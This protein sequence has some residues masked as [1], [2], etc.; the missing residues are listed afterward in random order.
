MRLRA[1]DFLCSLLSIACSFFSVPDSR[2]PVEPVV[3][4]EYQAKCNYG[5]NSCF[6]EANNLPWHGTQWNGNERD[7]MKGMSGVV[8]R[9][10]RGCAA[11]R[12]RCVIKTLIIQSIT[13]AIIGGRAVGGRGWGF[14]SYS[15]SIRD[16]SGLSGTSRYSLRV[17][18]CVKG[19]VEW[20]GAEEARERTVGTIV[21]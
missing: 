18:T 15:N 20:S 21:N 13:N 10:D 5:W 4:I 3:L 14:R 19:W 12:A 8:A 17:C 1:Y 2:S 9:G 11:G 7:R 16:R 6:V